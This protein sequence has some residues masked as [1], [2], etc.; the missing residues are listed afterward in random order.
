M[1]TNIFLE[2]R[3]RKVFKILEHLLYMSD[4]N[5]TNES[6]N[7]EKKIVSMRILPHFHLV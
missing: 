1:I 6:R 3:K 2:N 4:E 7:M 5:F